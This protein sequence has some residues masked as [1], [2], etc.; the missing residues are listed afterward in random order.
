MADSDVM[1]RSSKI[2]SSLS[3]PEPMKQ[4]IIVD[5]HM[6]TPNVDR[7]AK[8]FLKAPIMP[9]NSNVKVIKAMSS[10]ITAF[11]SVNFM[12]LLVSWCDSVWHLPV[13]LCSFTFSMS[14]ADAR[15]KREATSCEMDPMIL[16][17]MTATRTALT[18]LKPLDIIAIFL[19]LS[20]LNLVKHFTIATKI[21][22]LSGLATISLYLTLLAL[23]Y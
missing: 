22:L 21:A 5:K 17:Q 15:A 10:M 14:W 7:T 3:P 19:Q 11:S 1:F 18:K 6:T 12:N 16:R 8:L 2:I 23:N 4:L 9:I 20:S 13:I